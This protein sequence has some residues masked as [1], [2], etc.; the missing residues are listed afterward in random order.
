MTT[1]FFSLAFW[2]F[3][4]SFSFS[5]V[6]NPLRSVSG[7]IVEAQKCNVRE[8]RKSK[9]LKKRTTE[10]KIENAFE[11]ENKYKGEG[12]VGHEERVLIHEFTQ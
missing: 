3:D 9:R 4:C 12:C 10:R 2:F 11:L 7:K 6:V 5:L 1:F 8:N